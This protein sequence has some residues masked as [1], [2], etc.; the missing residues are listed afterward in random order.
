ME[1]RFSPGSQV[2]AKTVIFQGMNLE[3][4]RFI[5]GYFNKKTEITEFNLD[6][7]ESMWNPC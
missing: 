2:V 3:S 6:S 7:R 1:S 5:P 4:I